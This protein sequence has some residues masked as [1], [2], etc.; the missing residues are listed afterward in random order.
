M[1]VKVRGAAGHTAVDALVDMGREVLTE[2][3]MPV[4]VPAAA[5]ASLRR[6]AEHTV[7]AARLGIAMRDVRISRGCREINDTEG[8]I[9]D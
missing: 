3:L 8:G 2:R 7:E 6:Q 1:L 4:P 5:K 9:V